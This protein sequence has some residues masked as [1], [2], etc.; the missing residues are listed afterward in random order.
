MVDEEHLD[1]AAVMMTSG[2]KMQP[3]PSLLIR[4]CNLGREPQLRVRRQEGVLSTG[5][6]RRRHLSVTAENE[7]V[8]SLHNVLRL[9]SSA[10]VHFRIF[11]IS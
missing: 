4:Q 11:I 1:R 5:E 10:D 9:L 2:R 6:E 8:T 3:F 7:G